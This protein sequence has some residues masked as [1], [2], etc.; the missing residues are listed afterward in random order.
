M[1]LGEG[2]RKRAWVNQEWE[3]MRTVG[4][5][6]AHC[7]DSSLREAARGYKITLVGWV[8]SRCSLPDRVANFVGAVNHLTRYTVVRVV[9][10]S[11]HALCE[12]G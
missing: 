5:V 2:Q 3:K 7:D 9:H 11:P 6:V 8:A 10:P 12:H 4:A 1:V